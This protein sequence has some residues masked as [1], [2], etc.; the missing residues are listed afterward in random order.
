MVQQFN[1]CSHDILSKS[2]GDENGA[3]DISSETAAVK[4]VT[5]KCQSFM[6]ENQ[7]TRKNVVR[8][9]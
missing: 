1:P 2:H 7:S 6:K 3:R 8:I 4:T 9:N 5:L